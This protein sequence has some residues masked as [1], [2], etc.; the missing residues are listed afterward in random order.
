MKKYILVIFL[1]VLIQTGRTQNTNLDFKYAVKLYNIFSSEDY[2]NS[3]NDTNLNSF[4]YSNKKL[5]LFHPTFAFQWKTANHNFHEVE[6]IDFVFGITGEDGD[7]TTFGG[8]PEGDKKFISTYISM[9]YE[10]IL[11]FNKGKDTR[12]VPSLGFGIMPYYGHYNDQPAESN[13]F[14][15]S[16]YYTGAKVFLTPRLTY[17]LSP[18]FY[19]DLNIPLC[20]FDSYFQSYKD[21]DPTLPIKDQKKSTFNFE[22]FPKAFSGRLGIGLKF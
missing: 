18:K 20:L 16:E 12:M 4:R 15:S 21:E 17:H 2:S 14:R 1:I 7:D 9:R 3:D 6:L 22:A 19:I 11:N 13:S 5:R 10:Y 8:V